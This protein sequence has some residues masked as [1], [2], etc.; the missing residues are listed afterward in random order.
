MK[1]AKLLFDCSTAI[2]QRGLNVL[3][4]WRKRGN[5]ALNIAQWKTI[6]VNCY[7][8]KMT[9]VMKLKIGYAQ[10]G[11]TDTDYDKIINF[12]RPGELTENLPAIFFW[13]V[14]RWMGRS[15]VL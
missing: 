15:G 4:V 7:K 13:K 2:H 9:P 6:T 3:K 8:V 10:M 1:S 11:N 5:G 14:L 12:L